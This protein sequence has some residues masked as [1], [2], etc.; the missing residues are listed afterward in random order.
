MRFVC[1]VSIVVNCKERYSTGCIADTADGLTFPSTFD[2]KNYVAHSGNG[3]FLQPIGWL[4]SRQPNLK[5]AENKQNIYNACTCCWSLS[6]KNKLASKKVVGPYRLNRPKPRSRP[7]YKIKYQITNAKMI[8]Y[9][10]SSSNVDRHKSPWGLSHWVSTFVELHRLTTSCDDRRAVAKFSNSRVR[11][12]GREVPLFW[13]YPN[14]Y[15]SALEY[16]TV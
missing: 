6:L 10:Q 14:S 3:L 8:N 5:R 16:V 9:R 11:N 13:R 1:A 12:K 4:A 2:N 7:T 15:P